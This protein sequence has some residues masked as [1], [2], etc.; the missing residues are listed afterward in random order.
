M[1][2]RLFRK[3]FP[4]S[5]LLCAGC[6]Q[7][8]QAVPARAATPAT[9]QIQPDMPLR[10][11][12]PNGLRVVIVPDRLAPVV[13]TEINYLAG[14][15]AAPA[16]FPGTAH[17]LEHMMFRGSSGLDRDQLAAIGARL[18]GSYNA[19]TTENVTQFFYTAPAENLD[20]LLH[21]EA[22]RMDGLTLA[23]DDWAHERGA[24]EQEVSRDM[25]S[26]GYVYLSRL[27]SILFAGTPYEHDA[28]GTRPSFDRT[29]T[30]LLRRFYRDWYAPNNAILVIT[31]DVDPARTLALV[32]SAFAAIPARRLPPRPEIRPGPLHAQTLH[33]PTDYPMGLMAIA[34]RMPGQNSHDFATARILSDVLSSQ[35]GALYELVPQGHALLASFD[36]ITKADAGIGIAIAAFPKG[37]APGPLQARM[38]DILRGLRENGVP[39]DLV[40]AAKRKELAQLGFAANS[41]AG[42]AE[43]WSEALAIM[44]LQSPDDEAAAFASVTPEDVNRL[45]RQ[46]LDPQQSVTAILTPR[47]GGHTAA[48][49]GFG[50]SESFASIPDHPVSLPDWANASLRSIRPPVP[51]VRPTTFTLPNG[52]KLI[53]RPA[54]VSHTINLYGIIRQNEDMEEPPGKEGIADITDE[55]FHYGSTTHDRIGLQKAL[56]DIAATESAGAEF[57]LNVLTPDFERGL[58]L[59]AE[60]ELHPSLPEAA[61][62]VVRANT[63]ASL[64]GLLHSPDYLFGRALQAAVS[65][66]GDPSLRQASPAQVMKLTLADCRAF[67][68]AA[69]RPDL[70]TIV[71]TGDITPDAAYRAIARAFGPWQAIGPTPL[72]DLPPRPD[73]RARVTHVPDP[74]SMQATV[75]LPE[76]LGITV[77]NPEHFALNLGNE[78]LGSGFS[79]RLYRDLRVRTGY[80]YTVRSHLTWKRHRSAY[81]ISFGADPD[82]VAAARNAAVHDLITMQTEP[83]SEDELTMARAGLLRSL[84]LQSAS[85][86]TIAE[87]YLHF[88]NLG[89]PLNQNDIAAQAYYT[90]DAIAIRDAF[91]KW[92]C[93]ADLATIIKGPATAP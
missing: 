68:G 43:S 33:F 42:L 4:L 9:V 82:K 48:G 23:A 46:V 55:L 80:V 71:I 56:D 40:D 51:A 35:R 87:S 11:T 13:S 2:A 41:I 88:S 59:L 36:F 93:P 57:S 31:G 69:Y 28:L 79:S 26:P 89:L 21:I 66:P 90:M 1:I 20:V 86:D 70:T 7:S 16:G 10:A 92:V 14:S 47:D 77:D 44:G 53:V 32:R 30:T 37:S 29:D 91:R 12:L 83:V 58:A 18:G 64:S 45:A 38:Q 22:L 63:A 25:S 5:F 67:W 34:S 75:S 81:S 27:Q 54:A 6:L 52:L 19:D 85:L 15:A 3:T 65:P 39:A 72:V 60:N 76:S 74:S 8:G 17:A 62:R 78:I 84:S 24:I 61:F 50:G 73:S 49:K